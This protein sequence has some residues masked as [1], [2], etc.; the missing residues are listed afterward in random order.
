MFK[1]VGPSEEEPQAY[2]KMR[3]PTDLLSAGG[4]LAQ[5]LVGRSLDEATP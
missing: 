1:R 4:G 3:V 2:E 5:E